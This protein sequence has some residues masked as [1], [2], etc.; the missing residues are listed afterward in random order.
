MSLYKFISG[1]QLKLFIISVLIT[2]LISN[3]AYCAVSFLQFKKDKSEEQNLENKRRFKIRNKKP[4]NKEETIIPEENYEETEDKLIDNENINNQNILAPNDKKSN[5]IYQSQSEAEV[6]LKNTVYIK[7]IQIEGNK[8]I[9]VSE[10]L[11]HIKLIPGS[12]YN[13]DTIQ[14]NLK[15]IYDM[16]YFSD[17]MKAVPI[18]VDNNNIVLRIF[19]NENVPVTGF[20]IEGNKAIETGELL[21][22]LTSLEGKPQNLN[23]INQAIAQIEELYAQKGFILARVSNVTDDPDG[24][25]NFMIDEGKIASIKYEGNKKTKDYVINRNILTKAGDV[26]NEN[27]IRADLTR[28]YSTQA[29]KE[30]NRVIEKSETGYG[31]DVK[32]TLEEQRSATIS[33]GGGIDTTTGFFGMAGLVDNNLF[34]R[35]QKL[36]F[37]FLAGSG[38][39]LSDRSTLDR[40]NFQAEVSFM[41]PKF[42]A[43]DTSMMAKAFWRDFAS[44]QIPLA[45]E[46]R[47]GGEIVFGRK[48]K[49]FDN[50]NGSI[51]IGL[52]NIRIKEGDYNKI[53]QLYRDYNLPIENRAKQLKGGIFASISPSLTYDTR[54]N[55]M[56]PRNGSLV[57]IRLDQA[58]SFKDFDLTHARATASIKHYYPV[59]KKSSLALSAKVGGR[60]YGDMPEVMGFRLGGPYSVRGFRISEVGT[61]ESFIIGSAEIQTPFFFFDKIEKLPFLKNFKLAFFVDAGQVFNSYETD[62]LYNRPLKAISAGIGARLFIP[63]L[64]PLNVDYG[65]PLTN[66]GNGNRRGAFTFGIGDL[67]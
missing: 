48:F 12:V 37:N 35:G 46:K 49:D 30:V 9:P 33:L 23:L 56:S 19:I 67:Y 17:K 63:G 21:D 3:Q 50:L 28:L 18:I 20:T 47:Y 39:V 24:Y 2:V 60:L 10:I 64:G 4:D 8:L 41:E 61:G 26:Y 16:G 25:V 65:Y 27:Q 54:D 43:T 59:A 45:I 7:D 34:G 1:S 36:S 38:L 22:S 13:R 42:L 55:V 11:N 51:G 15:L 32:I 57:N 5:D 53:S 29:F 14:D 44:Y 58:F 62:K 31:Y 6:N 40:A 52:E 66:V